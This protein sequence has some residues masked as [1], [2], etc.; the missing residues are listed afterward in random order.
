VAQAIG[1]RTRG[2]WRQD[3]A[4]RTFQALRIFLNREIP[5]KM[6]CQRHLVFGAGDAERGSI[7]GRS[8]FVEREVRALLPKELNDLPLRIDL[9]RHV[10][11]PETRGASAG[12]NFLYD[13]AHAVPRPLT[14]DQLFRQLPVSHRIC[15]IY[16]HSDEHAAE[17]AT[18]LDALIGPGGSDDLTN[19]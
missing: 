18:A 5:W 12:Q 7:F 13:P 4:T 19:M 16:A 10:H 14:D 9:A 17:L 6:V 8:D 1:T 15:R 2:D 3:P 11:R